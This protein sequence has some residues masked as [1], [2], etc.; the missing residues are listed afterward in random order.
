MKQAFLSNEDLMRIPLG[1]TNFTNLRASKQIYVD[2]TA[3]IYKITRTINAPVFLS[4]PR[5]F[6]KSLLVS[7][8]ESLFSRGLKDFNGLAIEKLWTEQKKYHVIHLDFSSF[9]NSTAEQIK[10][11]LTKRLVSALQDFSKISTYDSQGKVNSPGFVLEEFAKSADSKSVVLLIDEYDAPFTHHLE[12]KTELKKLEDLFGDFFA[13]IKLLEGIFR[14]VF[15]TGITR[16]S[17]VSLFSAFN[18]LWDITLD[19]DFSSLTGITED[20]LHLYFGRYVEHAA[21]QL[22]LDVSTVYEKLR[23]TYDGFQFSLNT[24]CRVYNPW[25]LL[26][27]LARSA[28]GFQNYWYQSSGGTP[29]I[30]VNYL[31]APS[32]LEEFRK[33]SEGEHLVEISK[34]MSKS[35]A[36]HIPLDLLLLQAG[37]FTLRKRNSKFAKLVLPNDEVSDSVISLSLD[38]HNLKLSA[39]TVDK[40]DELAYLIDEGMIEEIVALFNLILSECISVKSHAFNDENSIR[41][42]IF[43]QINAENIVK[44]REKINA[45]GYSDLELKTMKTKLV[46]EFKRSFTGRSEEKALEMALEQVRERHYGDSLENRNLLQVAM[47]ISTT[48]KS[49][50]KW[51]VLS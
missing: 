21:L 1:A 22:N 46:I 49:I 23:N 45:F 2:K 43:S 8:L 17:H 36:A 47:V 11:E 20:E 40:L 34:M 4:R 9:A 6:G 24:D 13:S 10:E 25:S 28:Q 15:I 14:F 18:T 31:K 5:R 3:L 27:F 38:L 33:I 41:D 51:A 44:T 26:T 12:D 42:M 39:K 16:I 32:H 50:S 19:D 48:Q 30:L 35:D 29:A 37:Y 7:C